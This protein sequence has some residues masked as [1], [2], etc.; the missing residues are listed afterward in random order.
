MRDKEK[1]KFH[2]FFLARIN[3]LENEYITLNNNMSRKSYKYCDP[4]DFLELMI[5]KNELNYTIMIYN[6]LKSYLG[7]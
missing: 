6:A 5:I 3:I 1:K 4:V 7:I 2:E